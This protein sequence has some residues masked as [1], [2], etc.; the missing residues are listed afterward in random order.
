MEWRRRPFAS[1]TCSSGIEIE[2]K[3]IKK[4]IVNLR[5]IWGERVKRGKWEDG[6]KER[7]VEIKTEEEESHR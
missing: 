6:E 1:Q 7:R 5:A 4:G 3:P 2:N